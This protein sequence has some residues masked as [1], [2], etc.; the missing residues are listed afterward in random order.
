MTRQEILEMSRKAHKGHD[1]RELMIM[2]K[3]KAISQA[4]SLTVCMLLSLFCMITDGPMLI[5]NTAWTITSVMYAT[6]YLILS[7][8]LKKP[9]YGILG[10]L[11]LLV[12]F[13]Y[14]RLL[15]NTIF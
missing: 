5:S 12:F 6:D 11:W 8:K 9:F 2:Q 15:G 1:E 3:A 4:V 10:V 14:L 13:T 7:F